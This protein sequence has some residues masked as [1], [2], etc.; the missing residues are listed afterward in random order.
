MLI[1]TKLLNEELLKSLPPLLRLISQGAKLS[2]T[3][4]ISMVTL[5][6]PFGLSSVSASGI[7]AFTSLSTQND[8]RQ[9]TAKSSLGLR[10]QRGALRQGL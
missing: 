9:S 6:G 8:K 3:Y 5:G 10:R 4:D 2:L 7:A 1:E